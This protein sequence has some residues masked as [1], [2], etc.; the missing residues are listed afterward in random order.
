M[1]KAL[2]NRRICDIITAMKVY[3]SHSEAETIEWAKAYAATL[4]TGDVVLLEGEMGAGKTMLAKGL[5]AGM[6]IPDEV[7]SPT[8]AYVNEY[9][10]RVFHF[11]CYRIESAAQAYGLGLFDY[12]G[13][14]GVCIVEWGENIRELL[15]DGCKTIRICKTGKAREIEF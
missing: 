11:D 12:F 3:V 6:G 5:I 9:G 13:R 2:Q 14:G 15:P 7:T 4:K 10:G 8:Y 1:E